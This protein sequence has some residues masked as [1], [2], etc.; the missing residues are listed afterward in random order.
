LLAQNQPANCPLPIRFYSDLYDASA[1][2]EARHDSRWGFSA[3]VR[4]RQDILFDPGNS[5]DGFEHMSSAGVD[6][7]QSIWPSIAPSLDHHLGLRLHVKV[8]P[9]VKAYLPAGSR[10][11]R[12]MRYNILPRPN[13]P[14]RPATRT[15]YFD[16]KTIPS[17]TSPAS[18]FTGPT[19]SLVGAS[20]EM[21]PAFYL[22]VTRSVM[23]GD[24]SG[25]PPN[26]PGHPDLAGFPELSLAL[27]TEK[28]CSDTGCSHSKVEEIILATKAYLAATLTTRRRL[29]PVPYDGDYIQG[30]AGG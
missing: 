18:A 29:P 9:A 14:G 13:S 3:L 10:V 27:E 25:L 12:A 1:N 26:E 28:G 19:P 7:R 6:L 24:F 21:L 17:T 22:I 8:K 16:G 30:R 23:M 20:R 5:A 15:L 11:G 2:P 4:K